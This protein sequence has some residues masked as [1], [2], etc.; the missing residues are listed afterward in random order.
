M[1]NYQTPDP[2]LQSNNSFSF[3]NSLSSSSS[4]SIGKLVLPAQWREPENLSAQKLRN[5]SEKFN[6]DIDA[7][8]IGTHD[9]ATIDTIQ[10]APQS[11]RSKSNDQQRFIIKFNGNGMQ[12]TDAVDNFAYDAAKLKE[13][14]IAFNYR[15]V[16]N[17]KKAPVK[18]Q[19]LVTDGI[20]QVQRLLDAGVNPKNITLDGLSLGGAVATMV[21]Y[22]FHQHGKQ[23][24]LWNDRSL[25]SLSKVAARMLA[26]TLPGLVGDIAGASS[27]SS[28]WSAMKLTGWEVD[29]ASAYHAIPNEFKGYMVVAKQSNH[30]YGD[31]VIPHKAS[32]HKGVRTSEKI[33]HS[34]TGHK[35]LA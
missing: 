12:Y 17:S 29:V 34:E 28:A 7:G 16:G 21:A 19:D 20:A 5:L 3:L 2:Y 23:V 6:L 26:P 10:F 30:S 11:E 15:G 8:Y 32:L 27:E 24:H 14:V 31:G 18:F 22:H 9:D 1:I 25:S 4:Q 33:A 35:V 13:T